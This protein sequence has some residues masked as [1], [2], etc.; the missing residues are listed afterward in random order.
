MLL[1]HVSILLLLIIISWGK[2]TRR[3]R[4]RETIKTEFK[5]GDDLS[6]GDNRALVW[7]WV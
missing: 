3:K 5:S 2:K 1:L 7:N 6:C 4:E